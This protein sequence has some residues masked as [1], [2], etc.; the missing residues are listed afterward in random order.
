MLLRLVGV[1]LALLLEHRSALV[2]LQ[3]LGCPPNTG[4]R[5]PVVMVTDARVP[6]EVAM[7]HL[8]LLGRHLTIIVIWRREVGLQL[9]NRLGCGDPPLLLSRDTRLAIVDVDGLGPTSST[10]DRATE[11]AHL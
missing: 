7:G 1:E 4:I 8:G 10:A 11:L 6:V 2:A 3:L 5:S 9:V